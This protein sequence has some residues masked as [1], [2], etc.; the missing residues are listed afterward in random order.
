[1]LFVVQRSDGMAGFRAAREIDP[2]YAE[3]LR[4]AHERGLEIYAHLASVEPSG[5]VLTS[6]RLDVTV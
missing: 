5:I 2:A 6:R 3:A 4:D 1:M